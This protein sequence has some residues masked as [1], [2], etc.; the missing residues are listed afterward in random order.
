M[1]V[2]P[3]LLLLLL[4]LLMINVIIR[5]LNE[6]PIW[7]PK[8]NRHDWPLS[9]SPLYRPLLYLHLKTLQVCNDAQDRGISHKANVNRTWCRICRFWFKFLPFLMQVKFLI[10]KGEGFPTQLSK[11]Y[12]F[13]AK[14]LGVEFDS[15]LYAFNCQH[16]M[17]NVWD[18]KLLAMFIWILW[19][20]TLTCVKKISLVAVNSCLCSKKRTRPDYFA[21]RHYN[22]RASLT[23]TNLQIKA[24]S[25]KIN[26][27]LG[28]KLR[29]DDEL[30]F[31]V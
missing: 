6:V 31:L 26:L 15:G 21:P 24:V 9:T 11:C 27:R 3:A 13:H 30:T 7:I 2:H 29:H 19:F 17:V 10:S 18:R 12:F 1:V 5:N 4:S 23:L 25:I 22:F 20:G 28:Y 8:I 14:Y 16:N